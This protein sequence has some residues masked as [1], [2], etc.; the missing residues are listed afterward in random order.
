MHSQRI[1]FWQGWRQRPPAF[2]AVWTLSGTGPQ[3]HGL[4]GQQMPESTD[5]E[6]CGPTPVLRS[7]VDNSIEQTVSGNSWKKAPHGK[8]PTTAQKIYT[9]RGGGV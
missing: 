7:D 2:E 4:T 3:A 9:P 6:M 5:L 1:T 8:R